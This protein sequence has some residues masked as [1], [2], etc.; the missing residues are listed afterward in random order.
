MIYRIFRKYS[1]TLEV[2]TH[3]VIDMIVY[4]LLA[5]MEEWDDLSK[6]LTDNALMPT[7]AEIT[8]ALKDEILTRKSV[9]LDRDWIIQI[10]NVTHDLKPDI[11]EDMNII[12]HQMDIGNIR[13]VNKILKYAKET[14]LFQRRKADLIEAFFDVDRYKSQADK[15][16][17][18]QIFFHWIYDDL[19]SQDN[20]IIF[21]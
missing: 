17:F 4:S 15:E 10:K 9:D 18:Q 5:N 14:N 12:K 16:K 2:T 20:T 21:D 19:P 7:I 13:N 8:Q 6:F 3:H 11:F 1:S